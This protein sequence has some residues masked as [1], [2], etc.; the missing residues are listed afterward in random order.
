MSDGDHLE[1]H[2]ILKT[3]RSFRLMVASYYAGHDKPDGLQNVIPENGGN[4]EIFV[5]C[6][7]VLDSDL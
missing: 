6:M 3:G 4:Y 2:Q 1:Q 7:Q 5:L